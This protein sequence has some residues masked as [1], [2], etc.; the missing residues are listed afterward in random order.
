V[1]RTLKTLALALLAVLLLG[2]AACGSDDDDSSDEPTSEE[3]YCES[4]D[5]LKESL[6]ALLDLDVI[7]EGTNGVSAAI[8]NVESDLSGFLTAAEDVS[9]EEADALKTS[10]DDVTAAF[11]SIGDDGLSAE[12]TT[13]LI[14]SLTALAPAAEAVYTTLTETC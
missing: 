6:E 5:A 11:D 8:S 13:A 12:N 14:D 3:V 4:G 2:A 9:S 1:N 7:A 10:F